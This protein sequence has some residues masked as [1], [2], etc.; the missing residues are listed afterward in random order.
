MGL[1]FLGCLYLVLGIIMPM[2]TRHG[3]EVEVPEVVEMHFEQADS[4]LRTRGFDLV[5]EREQYDWN[6]PEGTVIN[7]NPEA[8][9]LT[10]PG[11]RVYVTISIGE[12]LFT[13]PNFVGKSERDA[14][15]AAQSAGLTID[16]ECFGYEYS[17]Y[18]PENVVMAQ[19]IPPGT[20]LRKDTPIHV[21]V[22]LGNIPHE[23]R[24]PD[25]VGQSLDRAKRVILTSGLE[26]GSV[27]FQIEPDLLPKTVISQN[28]PADKKTDRGKQVDMVVSLLEEVQED[29]ITINENTMLE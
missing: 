15:F 17:N 25:V 18:Y 6:Y 5:L 16:E 8:F 11:R 29:S 12:K 9:A 22:S 3:D 4:L 28:P 2:Y 13:M 21:T 24:V 20:K 23:F 14:T 10:K 7:Q 27:E 19:S 1:I 26:V